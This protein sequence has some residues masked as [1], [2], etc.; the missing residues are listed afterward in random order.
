MH[1]SS[2]RTEPNWQHQSGKSSSDLSEDWIIKPGHRNLLDGS[3][4]LKIFFFNHEAN[5]VS[6]AAH[7][8]AVWRSRILDTKPA[9]VL[10]L[11]RL[12]ATPRRALKFWADDDSGTNPRPH[13][14]SSV[15][16][17]HRLYYHT[18]RTTHA[19]MTG[20]SLQQFA[21]RFQG[22][23][24][25]WLDAQPISHEGWT[26]L[27]DLH[28][29][30]QTML[31]TAGVQA[32]CGPVLLRLSPTWVDDF[33]TFDKSLPK[34][35][36]GMPW[37]RARKG[38]NARKRCLD[39]IKAWHRYAQEH[40][41]AS[42]ITPDGHDPSYGSSLMRS[43]QEMW[44]KM[45][46]MDADACASEDLGIIWGEN[47]NSIPAA[48]WSL[49]HIFR[50]P[51][52][53]ASTR[54]QA[55][56]SF[57]GAATG[58]A[59]DARY[60]TEALTRNP[61]LQS[62]WSEVL[63]LYVALFIVR[64]ADHDDFHLPGGHTIPK[65]KMIV[66]DTHTAHHDASVWNQG[67]AQNPHPLDSF[68]AERFLVFPGQEKSGPLKPEARPKLSS[69]TPSGPQMPQTPQ[70]PQTAS[71]PLSPQAPSTPLTPL[72]PSSPNAADLD[73]LEP[74]FSSSGLAGAWVPFGGGRH[75]CPGKAFAKQEILLCIA[76][77]TELFDI[78]IPPEASMEVDLN[79]YGLG[80]LPPK[81]EIPVRIRRRKVE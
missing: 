11:T 67:D 53:L 28:A 51:K 42:Q 5:V 19:F 58:A 40:F 55:R 3:R 65:Q 50:D 41:D 35:L 72:T 43:R 33:W 24:V 32:M 15:A 80:S 9:A 75:Q 25:D 46:A 68:W 63:R 38:Y 79:Y 29:F 6:G 22:L 7:V 48:F 77:M 20:R 45:P 8:S 27:P 31:A 18:H 59:S 2:S 56:R 47:S 57:V 60:N 10:A 64:G 37:L 12:F 73:P 52:L 78:E 71:T 66:V 76:V 26:D 4:P 81:A 49:V 17:D 39:G 69:P 61:L 74:R 36:G 13:P 1:C 62:V 21:D 14:T 54:E 34:F 70:A 44:A 23:L 16:P 30:V